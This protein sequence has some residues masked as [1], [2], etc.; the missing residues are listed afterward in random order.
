MCIMER[1]ICTRCFEQAQM[2]SQGKHH[3]R[4]LPCQACPT[5]STQSCSTATPPKRSTRNTSTSMT[6]SSAGECSS[7]SLQST[8]LTSLAASRCPREQVTTSRLLI[9]RHP[10]ARCGPSK[11]TLRSRRC[12]F[13]RSAW[14]KRFQPRRRIKTMRTWRRKK[15]KDRWRM[16]RQHR[17]TRTWKWTKKR[18]QERMLTLRKKK[19]KRNKSNENRRPELLIKGNSFLNSSLI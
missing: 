2:I 7:K 5:S 18:S 13:T 12:F 17:Q 15:P 4:S 9:V 1:R 10:S 16:I 3:L 8:L 6:S 14:R 11:V 19:Q